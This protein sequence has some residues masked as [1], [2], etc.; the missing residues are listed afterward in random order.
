MFLIHEEERRSFELDF[1]LKQ[2]RIQDFGQG[3]NN[4][5]RSAKKSLPHPVV[6]SPQSLK[7]FN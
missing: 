3:G 7:K 6:F 4:F 5:A 2:A 1:S